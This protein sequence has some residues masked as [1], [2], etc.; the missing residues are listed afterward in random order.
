MN[1]QRGDLVTI[2][3]YKHEEQFEHTN[4]VLSYEDGLLTL[5]SPGN[6]RMFN[7]RSPGVL[8]VERATGR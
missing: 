6:E 4:T 2:V 3:F 8:S 7:L 5:G 1:L